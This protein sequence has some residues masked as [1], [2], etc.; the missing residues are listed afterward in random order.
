MIQH[1]HSRSEKYRD[2]IGDSFRCTV[3]GDVAFTGRLAKQIADGKGANLLGDLLPCLSK[4]DLVIANLETVVSDSVD[5]ADRRGTQLRS[6]KETISILKFAGIDVVGIANNHVMDCGPRGLRET[7][8]RLDAGDIDYFG[9]GMT[10]SA[11]RSPLVIERHGI[12]LAILGRNG[13]SWYAATR[14]HGGVAPFSLKECRRA[15]K[16]AREHGAD[17]VMFHIHS[18]EELHQVPW[19]RRIEWLRQVAAIPE[20]QVV[21]GGHQH[22][23]QGTTRFDGT[24]ALISYGN[25]LMDV[26]A[27]SAHDLTRY[28][29]AATFALDKQGCWAI[30]ET[31]FRTTSSGVV[32]SSSGAARRVF[33]Y[34]DW[35]EAIIADKERHQ[36]AW[37]IEC[38]QQVFGKSGRSCESSS[39]S[40]VLQRTFF[41]R[42]DKLRL[43]QRKTQQLWSRVR[44]P[45]YRARLWGAYKTRLRRLLAGNDNDPNLE[46]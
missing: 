25:L 37:E 45:H 13:H 31:P 8:D 38:Y 33:D 32:L 39:G 36:R 35:V 42:R 34:I 21:V 17:L 40:R 2:P 1:W 5:T 24:S 19:P 46:Q 11:A 22:I 14:N 3:L 7:M 15:V 23:Y 12:R 20:V 27:H 16:T 44:W 10:L 29:C 26:P 30:Q 6:P 28:G 41:A 4:S 9:A 18:G 43:I